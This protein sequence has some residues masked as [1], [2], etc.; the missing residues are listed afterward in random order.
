MQVDELDTPCVL[1]DLDRMERNLT[2]FQA[3]CDAEGLR[4]P[5]LPSPDPPEEPEEPAD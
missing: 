5:T 2:R 4:M 3:Y 1:I